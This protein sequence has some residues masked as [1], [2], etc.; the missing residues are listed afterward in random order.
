ML[1]RLLSNPLLKKLLSFSFGTWVAFLLGFI[2]TPITTRLFIP[3]EMGKASMFDLA[4]N[5]IAIIVVFGTDQAYVRFYYQEESQNR[6]HLLKKVLFLPS[7]IFIVLSIIILCFT[8]YT[9]QTLFNEQVQNIS[10]LL[11]AGILLTVVHRFAILVIRMQQKGAIF[12]YLQILMKVLS[13]VTILGLYL[14]MGSEAKVLIIAEII[15]LLISCLLALYFSKEDWRFSFKK[16]STKNTLSHILK[17]SSPLLFTTMIMWLFQSFDRL[18]I[19][20]FCNY[21]ELGIYVAAFRIVAVLNIFQISFTTFWSPVSYEHYEKNPD[22]KTFFERIHAYVALGMISLGIISIMGKD[23]I[24]LIVGKDYREASAIMPF[25]VFIPVMYTISET[26]VLG[27]NFSKKV[28]WALFISI[29]VC[30]TNIIGNYFLIPR[31]QGRGAAISTGLSYVLFFVL[32][33]AIASRYYKL[34]ISSYKLIAGFSI[35][36]WYAMLNTFTHLDFRLNILLGAASLSVI[37]L[38]YSGTIKQLLA[39]GKIPLAEERHSFTE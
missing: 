12:S 16:T 29:I 38:I 23:V 28:K 8:D 25:L 19:K 18:A 1:K 31:F 10:I 35:L 15:A 22:D 34:H 2:S 20:H 5:I 36:I 26:T 24:T 39:I 11:I 17:F 30:I 32:R 4:M 33:S 14:F 6:K 21:E 7:L 27:I 13:I 3:E 9:S 37:A